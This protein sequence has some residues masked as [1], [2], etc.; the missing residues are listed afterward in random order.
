MAEPTPDTPSAALTAATE[1]KFEVLLA[2]LEKLVGDLE[3]GKLSLEDSLSAFERGM[4]VSGQAAA[5]LDQADLRIE[6]LTGS[7]ENAKTTAFTGG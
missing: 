5:I 7:G 2:E 4:K 6:Q 3:G 1:P